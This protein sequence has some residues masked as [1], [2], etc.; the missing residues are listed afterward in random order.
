MALLWDFQFRSR[1]SLPWILNGIQGLHGIDMTVMWPP[2]GIDRPL[3]LLWPC[4][5]GFDWY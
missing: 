3:M 5:W 1:R 4:F 2:E